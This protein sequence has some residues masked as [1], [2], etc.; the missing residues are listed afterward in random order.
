MQRD[1][2]ET[3]HPRSEKVP[4]QEESRTAYQQFQDV[5]EED[6]PEWWEAYLELRADGWYWRK[7]AYIAWAA[8]PTGKRWPET[9]KELATEVLGL[10][11][12]RSIRRWKNRDPEIQETIEQMQVA[13]LMKHRADVID[14]LIFVARMKDPKA[15]SDRKLFLEMT[16]D[17]KSKQELD[18]DLDADVEMEGLLSE[19]EQEAVEDALRSQ[20]EAA[21][22]V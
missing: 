19:D 15:H 20:A 4:G 3:A 2:P 14:S 5:A 17:Y 8:T 16:G 11:S 22:T 10:K 21:Q 6:A 13:P 1:N 9:Q 7:A 18:I 12:A